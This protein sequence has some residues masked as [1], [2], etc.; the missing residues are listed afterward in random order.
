MKEDIT[1]N[2]SGSVDGDAFLIGEERLESVSQDAFGHTAHVETL[3]DIVKEV[4]TPW[5]IALYGV[6]G[7]GKSTIVN[8]LY[9]RIRASQSS[10]SEYEDIDAEGAST[11]SEFQNTLCVSFNAWKHAEDSVRTELLLDLNKSLQDE[12]DRRFG[13]ANT[14]PTETSIQDESDSDPH[15]LYN[16]NHGVL[17]SERIINILYNVE[18]RSEESTKSVTQAVRKMDPI[19]SVTI[20]GG[21]VLLFVVGFAMTSVS[22]PPLVRTGL[23]VITSVGIVGALLNVVLDD[24]RESRKEVDKTLANPQHE[25]SGAY[26]NLFNAIVDET[27]Q[28]YRDNQDTDSPDDID[29]IVITIDDLDRCRSQTTYQILIALKSFLSHDKC[30][31]IIPCDEDALYKHLEA[32]DQGE[33]LGD[34]INQQNFLA[35]FFETELEIP[36]PSEN[37]LE[38]YF[39]QRQTQFERS[40][41]PRSLQVLKDAELNTPRRVTRALNRL[42]VL[43]ELGVNRDVI[44]PSEEGDSVASDTDSQVQMEKA[45]LAFISVLQKDYPRFHAELER[46]PDLL[47]EVF[48]ELG[49]GF[50]TGDRQGLDPVLD[51]IHVSE[52]RR[53]PLLA[54]LNA[55]QDVAREIESPEPYL[56]LS[57]ESP[58]PEEIFKARFDRN[59]VESLREFVGSVREQSEETTDETDTNT[60]EHREAINTQLLAFVNYTERKVRDETTQFEALPTAIGI[61]DAFERDHQR[62]IAEAVLAALQDEQPGELLGDI[63]LSTLEPIFSVLSQ[64]QTKQFL[65]LYVQSIVGDEGL[66]SDNFA[67]LINGPGKPF[68]DETIQREF[69]D[70]I[71]SAR[72]RGVLTDESLGKVLTDVR[73][74][75]PE[76]YTPELVACK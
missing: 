53:D 29:R 22:L 68:E 36:T 62:R 55:S 58:D 2:E 73:T 74:N 11:E 61:A 64:T 19:F 15:E 5:H 52:E 17:S 31:Y 70:T 21:L 13:S 7:S 51:E 25:W 18:D 6:W 59:R 76:L 69:T 47:T 65:R 28:Q 67:S 9:K 63:E 37:R 38:E 43:N 49:G 3:E 42:T 12:L 75:K 4:D 30:V 44:E 23:A 57:G 66:R 20:V 24:F 39:E 35:K 41:E 60:S 34:T 71:R 8:L 16:Q 40:F 27:Q 1:Q 46:D 50:S 26:E 54:F 10:R 45:F 72:Q 56:R 32:A 14:E 48:D 33:Y